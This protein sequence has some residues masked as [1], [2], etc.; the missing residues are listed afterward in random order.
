M[1]LVTG[2]FSAYIYVYVLISY[3]LINKNTALTNPK[4]LSISSI[5]VSFYHCIH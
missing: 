5:S 4:E 2:V 3:T 1:N